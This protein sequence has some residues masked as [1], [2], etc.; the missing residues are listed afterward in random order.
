VTQVDLPPNIYAEVQRLSDE[1]NALLERGDPE[2]AIEKFR[3]ALRHLPEPRQVWSAATWLYTAI[4]DAELALGQPHRAHGA[5]KAAATSPD[6]LTNPYVQLRYGQVLSD[7]GEHD[8]AAEALAKAAMLGGVTVFANAGRLD[9]LEL[10]DAKLRA[11]EGYDSWL[12]YAE[13]MDWKKREN[14]EDESLEPD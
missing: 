12:A 3:A 7:L 10:V 14:G 4:G 11:P 5:L 2:S 6:G 13:S 9:M 8:G 1:G